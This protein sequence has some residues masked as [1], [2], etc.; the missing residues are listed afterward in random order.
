MIDSPFLEEVHSCKGV[1]KKLRKKIYKFNINHQP[2]N[3]KD[4]STIKDA[5]T[6]LEKR[7]LPQFLINEL[8]KYSDLTFSSLSGFSLSQVTPMSQ[9]AQLA[10]N[11]EQ[12]IYEMYH[13][14]KRTIKRRRGVNAGLKLHKRQTQASEVQ[15]DPISSTNITDMFDDE[16][17]NESSGSEEVSE[18]F[19]EPINSGNDFEQEFNNSDA[20]FQSTM[21]DFNEIEMDSEE[22]LFKC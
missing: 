3:H 5:L 21:L 15:L 13:K 16:I 22:F 12:E 11:Q 9:I 1:M 10:N 20:M 4:E 6:L 17:Q 8:Q 14:N 7:T 2:K 18:E 19:F